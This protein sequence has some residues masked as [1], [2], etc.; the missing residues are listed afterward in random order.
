[1]RSWLKSKREVTARLW[2][3]AARERLKGDA[4][5][6]LSWDQWILADIVGNFAADDPKDR[7]ILELAILLEETLVTEGIVPSDF[8]M[9]V[10][11]PR[12]S[13]AAA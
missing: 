11:R 9:V 12:P 8:V 4:W 1:M 13:P 5:K 10:A 2:G 6:R 7:A 3:G